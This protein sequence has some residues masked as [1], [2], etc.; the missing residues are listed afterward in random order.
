[1]RGIK[2]NQATP[3]FHQWRDSRQVWG[4]NF[5]GKDEATLFANT[6]MQALD[7]LNGKI[8]SK[9]TITSVNKVHLI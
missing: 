1:M 8:N 2:Y 3:N 5:S 6:M 4:L 7:V 9:N